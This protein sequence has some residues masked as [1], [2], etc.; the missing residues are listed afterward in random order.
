MYNIVNRDAS[1][2]SAAIFGVD[3]VWPGGIV[4]PPNTI[5]K[6]VVLRRDSVIKVTASDIGGYGGDYGG[7]IS[8]KHLIDGEYVFQSFYHGSPTGDIV[9]D[10]PMILGIQTH[11]FFGNDGTLYQYFS[12]FDVLSPLPQGALGNETLN[13]SSF[14]LTNSTPNGPLDLTTIEFTGVGANGIPNFDRHVRHLLQTAIQFTTDPADDD[15]DLVITA[16]LIHD[17]LTVFEQNN[18]NTASN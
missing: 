6:G 16:Q 7:Q 9:S 5:S 13:G 8:L 12:L 17:S 4:I 10:S 3:Q 11:L 1:I 18:G 2:F 14:G 15:A